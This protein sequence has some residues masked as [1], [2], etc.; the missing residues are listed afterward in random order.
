MIGPHA[1]SPDDAFIEAY[2]A[3]SD[4]IF[5]YCYF[6]V[7]D[8]QRAC[9]LMQECFMRTWQSIVDGKEIKSMRAF[10]YRV[11]N[12]LII[13]HVRKKKEASLDA[14]TE[15]GFDPGNDG[16]KEIEL[17]AEAGQ[18]MKLLDRIDEEHRDVVVMRYLDDLS[19]KEIAEAIGETEN[20]V[21]VRLHRAMKKLR[22][23]AQN[24]GR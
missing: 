9:E 13:D 19:P 16:H 24:Y 6:R 10:L 2:D 3:Y 4:A 15:G 21:S 23:F 22:E 8:R 12:N 11:A 1:P 17:A 20:V 7:Y 14:M 18:V 5:R